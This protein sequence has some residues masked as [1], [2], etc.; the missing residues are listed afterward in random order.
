LFSKSEPGEF[1]VKT[2][3]NAIDW[4]IDSIDWT[5]NSQLISFLI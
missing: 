1:S 4:M 5:F 2:K 3:K